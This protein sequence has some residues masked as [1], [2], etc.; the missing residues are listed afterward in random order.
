MKLKY[1]N[2]FIE[3]QN[4]G[5]CKHRDKKHMGFFFGVCC[6]LTGI[7]SYETKGTECHLWEA[8]NEIPNS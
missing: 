4:C 3:G 8:K 2:V 5:N 7:L 1:I 6:K